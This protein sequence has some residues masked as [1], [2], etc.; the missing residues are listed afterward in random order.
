MF[1]VL[2]LDLFLVFYGR[3]DLQP[4]YIFPSASLILL[5]AKLFVAKVHLLFEDPLHFFDLVLPPSD[6]GF[7]VANR[8]EALFSSSLVVNKLGLEGVV[9]LPWHEV[10]K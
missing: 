2:F 8:L 1:L 7:E 4:D 3:L 6:L 9:L 10:L 5:L